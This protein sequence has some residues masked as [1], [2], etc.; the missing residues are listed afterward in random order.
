MNFNYDIYT[1]VY[2]LDEL[3]IFGLLKTAISSFN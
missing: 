2:V 1:L 3:D